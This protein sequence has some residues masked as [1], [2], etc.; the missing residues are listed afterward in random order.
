ML[1]KILPVTF[2]DETRPCEV[3]AHLTRREMARLDDLDQESFELMMELAKVSSVLGVNQMCDLIANLLRS[4]ALG[5][6]PP[7]EPSDDD[8]TDFGETPRQVLE[9]MFRDAVDKID[10]GEV[11]AGEPYSKDQIRE[12]RNLIGDA[13]AQIE[14]LRWEVLFLPGDFEWLKA[15]FSEFPLDEM[16]EITHPALAISGE[17]RIKAAMKGGGATPFPDPVPSASSASAWT[18]PSGLP[19]LPTA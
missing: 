10:R 6:V 12:L 14:I 17:E 13:M 5:Q 19:V 1:S 16:R 18:A 2:G 7:R 11:D 3:K 4:Y 8:P 15:S 9:R